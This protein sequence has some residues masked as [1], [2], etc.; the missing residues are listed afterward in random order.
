MAKA[1]Y[2]F[3]LS[4]EAIGLNRAGT[5]PDHSKRHFSVHL[6]ELHAQEMDYSGN[7]RSYQHYSEQI[8]ESSG[9]E[10]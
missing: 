4:T 7:N 10:T 2:C 9:N 6:V 8:A 5:I 1:P 3:E